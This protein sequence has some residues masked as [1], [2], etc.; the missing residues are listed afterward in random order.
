MQREY[1]RNIWG[2]G[3]FFIRFYANSNRNFMLVFE[4]KSIKKKNMQ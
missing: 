2:D 1:V 3:K 4:K